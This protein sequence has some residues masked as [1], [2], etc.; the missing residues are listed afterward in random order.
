MNVRT[1]IDPDCRYV[2]F[3]GRGHSADCDRAAHVMLA[4]AVSACVDPPL[5]RALSDDHELCGLL[6]CA[7]C[8]RAR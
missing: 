1:K 6:P 8:R 5:F 3:S 4:L 2:P 7:H